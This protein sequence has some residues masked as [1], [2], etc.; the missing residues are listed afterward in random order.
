MS[1]NATNKPKTQS[2]P[3]TPKPTNNLPP[4][5][6]GTAESLQRAIVLL[7]SRVKAELTTKPKRELVE[8][9]GTYPTPEQ[10]FVWKTQLKQL[11]KGN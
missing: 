1:S 3:T 2:P 11:T 7:G 8:L 5:I 10:A 9:I 4:L 6:P